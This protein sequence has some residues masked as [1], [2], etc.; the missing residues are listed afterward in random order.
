VSRLPI[1]VRL[2]LA[3]AAA[4]ALLLAALGAFL[5][6]QVR[7]SLDEQV[8][9]G[10]RAQAGAVS[11]GNL[12]GGALVEEDKSI[13][14]LIGADGSVLAASPQRLRSALVP[15]GGRT[16]FIDRDIAE[17]R[18]SPYRLLVTQTESGRTVVVGA[19][20]DE[21]NEALQGL[22][23]ALFVGGPIAL[24]LA[25]IAGYLLAGALL[26][27]V[28]LMRRRAAEISTD[29]T[30]RKL[31]L[32]RAHD[33]IFR[34]GQ[35]LNDML[36]RLEAG[37]IRERRFVADAS[38]ELRTP[39]ALLRTEL[40]LARRRP[41]TPDELRVALDSAAAEVDRLSRLAE[42]LLVLAR[43]DEG[44]LALRREPIAVPDL[45]ETV[46]RRF[47]TQI[48]VAAPD[49]ETIVG[50]RLRLEQA[51]GNLV[52]NAQRYGGGTIRLEAE[53]RDARMELRVTDE[54]NGFPV[55]LLPHAFD[56]FTR[57]DEARAGGGAGLG[58]ALV[59]AVARAHGGTAR[60]AN[61]DR[62]GAV[63]TLELPA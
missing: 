26:R 39:L 24:V 45:L 46:A 12:R 8:N 61:R 18:N 22:L 62:S 60:A 51:L 63:V 42:D 54:G 33:E 14:Q 48:D 10:L 1:R 23:A 58:L 20:L 29:T 53:R 17:V 56:R 28:E 15:P 34:L 30:G 2:S 37:L 47:G 59:D 32:P 5:F 52:D 35:T 25:T 13:G 41:R 36:A 7:S 11:G 49:G 44:R 55:A 50:D 40:E 9:A 38:H 43:A 6:L 4:M 3:F 16:R 27:P 21:R 19:S 57:G 31:P